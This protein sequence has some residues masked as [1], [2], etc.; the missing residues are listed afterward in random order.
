MKYHSYYITPQCIPFVQEK[1]NAKVKQEI[2][3][4]NL[5]RTEELLCY[6]S[7]IWSAQ[8]A[9]RRVLKTSPWKYDRL[10]SHYTNS[11][12]T[13]KES[14]IL[15]CPCDIQIRVLVQYKH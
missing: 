9:R 12:D 7:S 13:K 2:V 14:V 3:V 11:P 1:G 15:A 6:H 4:E 5:C 8:W 10:L